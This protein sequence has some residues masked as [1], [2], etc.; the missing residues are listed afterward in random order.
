MVAVKVGGSKPE[1]A[2]QTIDIDH[3]ITRSFPVYEDVNHAR[4]TRWGNPAAGDPLISE[5]SLLKAREKQ[6][7]RIRRLF[8]ALLSRK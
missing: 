2:T 8:T 7:S 5:Q 4:S 3:G 6:D 1:I